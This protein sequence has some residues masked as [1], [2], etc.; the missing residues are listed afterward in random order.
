MAEAKVEDTFKKELS[1]QFYDV[2]RKVV[3]TEKATRMIEFENKLVFEVERSASKPVIKLLIENELGKKVKSINTVN[4]ITGK[5]RAIVTFQDE[6]AASDL[7]SEL[8]MV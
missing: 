6:G 2:I 5:K 8:G 4:S 7:S 1:K 3:V